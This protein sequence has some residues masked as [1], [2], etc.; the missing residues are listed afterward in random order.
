MDDTV[1]R[2]RV[3]RVER[4]LED[5]EALPDERARRPRR[6]S[7]RRCST[8]TARG[9]PA[10]SPCSPSATTTGRW[11]RRWQATSSSS[12]LLLLHGLHPVAVEERVRGALAERAPVPRVA[13]RRRRAA[14]R[15]DDGVARLRLQGSCEGCPS[16]AATLKLAIE[17]AIHAAAPDVAARR[18]RG[19]VPA[20][21]G[22]APP[23]LLQIEGLE[24]PAPKRS[25]STAG[26]MP[27]AR[28]AASTIVRDVD[29]EPVLFL[30][31]ERPDVRVPA[32]VPGLRRLARR[33]AARPAA[34]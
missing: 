5:V 18:G 26:G 6:R 32:P 20:T 33:G 24:P 3:A 13:R 14:R 10:S 31:L 12:H 19:A 22:A 23:A 30:R 8:S 25:W 34:S 27:D 28:P 15:R 11:Q 29:G 9:W 21:S 17:E 7:R 1:A 16:S 2:E 4:L